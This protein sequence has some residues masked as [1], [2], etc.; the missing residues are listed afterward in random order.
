MAQDGFKMVSDG[1][2]MAQDG[3]KMAHD[4]FKMTQDC[5]K[6]RKMVQAWPQDGRPSTDG[7]GCVSF[8]RPP[9]ADRCFEMRIALPP[10]AR[11]QMHRDTPRCATRVSC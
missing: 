11:P 6:C 4:G 1:A 10:A 3:V 8:C 9:P 7:Y 5:S 2:K